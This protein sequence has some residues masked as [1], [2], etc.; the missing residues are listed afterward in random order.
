MEYLCDLL[1]F[2]LDLAFF[3][4][5]V[6]SGQSWNLKNP[7]LFSQK[8]QVVDEHEPDVLE[9]FVENL[10]LEHLAVQLL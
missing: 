3:V 4:A 5:C 10:I 1:C 2:H 6:N 7:L 9:P 8:E